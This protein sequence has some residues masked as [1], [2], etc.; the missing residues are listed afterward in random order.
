MTTADEK[1][2]YLMLA[3]WTINRVNWLETK[4]V[5]YTPPANSRCIRGYRYVL[6]L[7]KAFKSQKRMD[8]NR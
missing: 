7:D 8:L 1:E 6:D 5:V 4:Y 2:M 3:G